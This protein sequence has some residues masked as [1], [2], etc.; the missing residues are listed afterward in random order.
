MA[1]TRAAERAASLFGQ[2]ERL[3]FLQWLVFNT[4]SAAR[5]AR[6]FNRL[7]ALPRIFSKVPGALLN[8][9]S[10]VNQGT[11]VKPQPK[12]NTC[13]AAPLAGAPWGHRRMRRTGR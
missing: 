7:G 10:M 12:P 9:M 1:L 8:K 13:P 2:G 11:D 4:G 5:V 3:L 6:R